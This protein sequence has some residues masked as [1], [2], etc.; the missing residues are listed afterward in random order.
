MRVHDT[1]HLPASF[2]RILKWRVR[3]LHTAHVSMRRLAFILLVVTAAWPAAVSSRAPRWIAD[4]AGAGV[5][6]VDARIAQARKA[7]R[8]VTQTFRARLSP[9]PIDLAMQSTIAGEGMV[10]A[11]LVGATLTVTGTFANLKTPATIAKI[12]MG[13][14]GIRGPAI[15]D[16]TVTKATSG[17]VGGTFEL[18][19]QQLDALRNT[20]LYIQLHSEKAPEGNLWGWLLPQESRR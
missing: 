16:L 5:E 11:T 18:S 2:W 4:P 12:H 6:P 10:T 3:V 9:V 1:A 19:P 20:R 17:S 13:V 7:T 15:L 14:K 8:S